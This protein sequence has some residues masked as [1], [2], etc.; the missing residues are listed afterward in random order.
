MGAKKFHQPGFLASRNRHGRNVF[1][2]WPPWLYVAKAATNHDVGAATLHNEMKPSTASE[3]QRSRSVYLSQQPSHRCPTRTDSNKMRKFLIIII[4]ITV[5]SPGNLNHWLDQKQ[6][7]HWWFFPADR[8][9]LVTEYS[10]CCL[11]WFYVF[12]YAL[13]PLFAG[14]PQSTELWGSPAKSLRRH[15]STARC[16]HET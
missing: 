10:T 15:L 12:K 9:S 2:S 3:Y 5:K 14:T 6:V 8:R 4:I 16:D 1:G 7:V 11:H 13:L